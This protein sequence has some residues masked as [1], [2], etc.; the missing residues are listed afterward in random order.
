MAR[1]SKLED[2][3]EQ[4][5]VLQAINAEYKKIA[6]EN[7]RILSIQEQLTDALV[8]DNR[9]SEEKL[10]KMRDVAAASIIRLDKNNELTEQEIVTLEN[11][12]K[13]LELRKQVNEAMGIGGGLIKSLAGSLGSFGKALGLEEA[14]QSMEEVAF[15]SADAGEKISK[16][17]VLGAG[18]KSIGTSLAGAFTDP[19]VIL[20]GIIK[21]FGE[22]QKAEQD[23]RRQTGQSLESIEGWNNELVTSV[24]Y[25]EGATML[26]KQL[27]VNASN[28]FSPE[29][30]TAAAA[31]TSNMGLAEESAAGLTKMAH[32]MG[33]PLSAVKEDM[34]AA[35]NDFVRSTGTSIN[36]SEIMDEVGQAS[37]AI[38]VSMGNNVDQIQAAAM[39][40]KKLGV[41]LEQVDKIAES[42][43]DFES[44]INAELEAELLTGKQL[45]LEKARQAALMNDIETVA[46]EIGKQEAIMESFATGNR[47]QQ[48]AAA[49]AL[50][51]SRDEMAEMVLQQNLVKLG[52]IEAAAAASDMSIDEAERLTTSKQLSKSVEKIT[53]NLSKMLLPVA[54]LLENTFVMHTTMVAIGTLIGVKMLKGLKSAKKEMTDLWKGAG[55]LKDR[56]LSGKKDPVTDGIGGKLKKDLKKV[57]GGTKGMNKAS[58]ASISGFLEGLAKGL[59]ALADPRVLLGLGAVTLAIM[60]MGKALG[61]AAPGIKAFGTVILSVFSGVGTVITAVAEGFVT[62]MGALNM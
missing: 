9:L 35:A 40:A 49:K 62:M 20:S 26:S 31:L 23:F 28:I 7:R 57:K 38:K 5:Q 59:K 15:N 39:E 8:N 56:L 50:G 2:Y 52:S 25:I 44:S 58:G 24:E 21:S 14:A 33:K 11:V 60:G 53:Q 6:K 51:M 54:G 13:E 10:K 17:A 37:S 45:N 12:E 22:L 41:S 4:E 36:L 29:D 27:G 19:A 61:M 43:L 55:K 3:Q 42:L 46:K 32:K 47:I 18:M 30:I 34:A 1:K 16:T 48:E